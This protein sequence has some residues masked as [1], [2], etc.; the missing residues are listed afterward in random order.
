MLGGAE[1]PRLMLDDLLDEYEEVMRA[2]LAAKS[3]NQRKKWRAGKEMALKVLLD[4]VGNR[5]V[6]SLTRADAL[7]LRSHWQDRVVAG[8]V[9]IATANR[10]IGHVSGMYRADGRGQQLNLPEIFG[11]VRIT[12]GRDRQRLA[13]TPDFVQQ[14]I[15]ADGIF[16][17]LNPEA[18]RIIY[19][20]VE[21]GLRL[22]EAANLTAKCI[23]LDGVVPH[24]R[25][26]PEGRGFENK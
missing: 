26:Q 1:M 23:C 18:R 11:R 9:E 21:T 22:S 16:E 5:A 25:V 14:R 7:K 2:T 13:Y 3:E 12:G 15:L 8:E 17:D 6:T 10:C 24:V 19:L 20:L 4:A